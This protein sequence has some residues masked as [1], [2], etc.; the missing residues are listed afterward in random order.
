MNSEVMKKK[1]IESKI[2]T[3]T[4]LLNADN[5]QR[6]LPAEAR[7]NAEKMLSDL[8]KQRN[9]MASTPKPTEQRETKKT[10]TVAAAPQEKV[11]I[12]FVNGTVSYS[13]SALSKLTPEQVTP[14]RGE[15]VVH[16]A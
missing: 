14:Y 7:Q 9:V 5:V 16:A 11:S 2:L 4:N 15:I 6:K 10:E 3:A 12:P 1:E 8:L 13:Q